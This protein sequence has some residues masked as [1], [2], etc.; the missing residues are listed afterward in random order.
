MSTSAQ[1]L[2]LRHEL[3]TSIDLSSCSTA[4]FHAYQKRMSQTHFELSR[5]L[6]KN[7][8]WDE[9]LQHLIKAA[10]LDQTDPRIWSALA[11]SLCYA[12][13]KVYDERLESILMKCLQRDGVDPQS[14]SFACISMAKLNPC[15][16]EQNA[17]L[18]A[19]MERTILADYDL[20]TLLTASRK[21]YLLNREIAPGFLEAL[22]KQCQKTQGVYSIT[23]EETVAL[24]DPLLPSLIRE[25][26]FPKPLAL[27]QGFIPSF[28]TI[29]NTVSQ[30]VAV[31]YEEHPYPLWDVLPPIDPEVYPRR[32]FDRILVAG[33]GTG[34][35][36]LMVARHFPEKLI[37]A[38]DLS[39]NSLRYAKAKAEQLGIVN[40]VFLQ[41][42]LLNISQLNQS[43]D[44]IECTGVLHHMQNPEA[45]L[46][47]LYKTLEPEGWMH[48]GLYSAATRQDV[49]EARKIIA[50]HHFKPNPEDIRK[51]RQLL[52]SL[53]KDNLARRVCQSVDFY[54]LSGCRD[55]LFHTQEQQFT[56]DGVAQLLSK[57]GL[58]FETFT[59]QGPWHPTLKTLDEGKRY[60]QNH[61]EAFI[62]MYQFWV[63]KPSQGANRI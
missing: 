24:S 19:L 15:P 56:L 47:A 29:S 31:Q 22:V 61:P 26:Y 35:H 50:H 25:C 12:E 5:L 37:T 49:N 33:C 39:A 38:I 40:V 41:G 20:E 10:L 62:D 3:E 51:A 9:V 53:P 48:L 54:S 43:Y 4:D 18:I 46:Q 1:E 28:S 17:L 14:I 27:M 58:T 63:S 44:L 6:E 52:R 60:E 34:R 13:F 32:S 57:V 42:D 21:K 45:G 36:A 2:K 8:Q 55:F 16:L 7:K 23:E 59:M 30:Q 11:H